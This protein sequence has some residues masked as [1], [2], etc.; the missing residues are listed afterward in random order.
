MGGERPLHELIDDRL[1]GEL[2][3]R[4]RDETGGLRLTGEGST[5]GELVK[6]VL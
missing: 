1:L 5:L 2:L 6:A 4:S 3:A